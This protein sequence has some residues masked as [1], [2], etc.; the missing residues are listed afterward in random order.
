MERLTK[1]IDNHF[2]D[3]GKMVKEYDLNDEIELTQFSCMENKMK[4]YVDEMPKCCSKCDRFCLDGKGRF[5]CILNSMPDYRS[6]EEQ[7]N[8][9]CKDC[10]LHSLTIH[11]EQVRADERKKVVEEIRLAMGGIEDILINCG[12]GKEDALCWINNILKQ[13]EKGERN[14]RN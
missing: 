10:P 6:L 13:V 11:D 1:C 8:E 5:R 4:V 2:P 12:N 9:R 7:E 14:E 3:I